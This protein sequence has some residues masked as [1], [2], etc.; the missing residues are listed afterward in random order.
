MG[1]VSGEGIGNRG[2]WKCVANED[3]SF[4]TLAVV[5]VVA[6]AVVA[7]VVTEELEGVDSSTR[8]CQAAAVAGRQQGD[9]RETAGSGSRETARRQQGDSRQR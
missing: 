8:K 5:V 7:V 3:K 9:S 4:E 1:A 6:V 2:S